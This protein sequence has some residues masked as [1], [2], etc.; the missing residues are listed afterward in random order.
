MSTSHPTS[1]AGRAKRAGVVATLLVSALAVLAGLFAAPAGAQE[2]APEGGHP[3]LTAEQRQCMAD[4]G[5]Q[6]PLASQLRTKEQRQAFR[7]AAEE[8]G[9]DLPAG[10]FRHAA[11]RH[12]RHWWLNLTAE[13]RQCMQDQGIQRPHGRPT[14]DQ[15]QAFRDAA[16]ACGIDLPGGAPTS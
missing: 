2:A 12:A 16:A 3:Q 7:A 10:A 11:R 9:I 5:Y 6:L 14:A 15:V 8:C 13:Q 1:P 4:H